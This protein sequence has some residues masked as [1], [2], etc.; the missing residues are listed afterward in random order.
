MM[1]LFVMQGGNEA[2]DN[3]FSITD[4][5]SILNPKNTGAGANPEDA[6]EFPQLQN[7][8]TRG[9]DK[10]GLLATI[11]NMLRTKEGENMSQYK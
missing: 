8:L 10:E 1:Q 3:G 7:S 4:L 9:E 2:P 5:L 6:I 11:L